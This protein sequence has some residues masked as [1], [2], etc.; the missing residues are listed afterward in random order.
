V[1]G[2]VIIAEH[3]P[4]FQIRRRFVQD[5]PDRMLSVP[6]ESRVLAVNE[7]FYARFSAHQDAVVYDTQLTSTSIG[8]VG[9]VDPEPGISIAM[10]SPQLANGIWNPTCIVVPVG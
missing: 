2:L 3:C 1:K 7:R 10:T 9:C 8:I 6:G 4:I 5:R